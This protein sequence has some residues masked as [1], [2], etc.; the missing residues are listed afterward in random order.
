MFSEVE[1]MIKASL[2]GGDKKGKDPAAFI[3]N[4]LLSNYM[5]FSNKNDVKPETLADLPLTLIASPV[6]LNPF[7]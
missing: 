1:Q 5:V 2:V 6:A 4:H 7:V 3:A